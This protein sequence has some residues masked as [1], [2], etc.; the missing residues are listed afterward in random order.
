MLKKTKRPEDW[1]QR[2]K[3]P[4]Y[5]MWHWNKNRNRYGMVSEWAEDFWAFVV[6][7]GEK[8][9]PD[10]RLR[11]H[12]ITEPMGPS[13]FFW[14]KKYTKGD[15][16]ALTREE[17]AAYMREYRKRRPRNVRNTALKGSYG[18][19]LQEWEALYEAQGGKCA[20]C[21]HE[22]DTDRYA[23]LSVDHCHTAGHVRGLLCNNCNRALGMFK[24][25][26]TVLDAAAAYLRR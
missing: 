20:I 12:E 10:Y 2:E 8:P 22:E 13:N 24:D 7:V 19:T 1:G 26:P 17:R 3:H 11:R 21:K 23:N 9:G 6:G 4:L 14:D 5:Q 16:N 15:G 18:I 25:D